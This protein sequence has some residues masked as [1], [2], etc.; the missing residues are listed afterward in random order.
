MKKLAQRVLLLA[1]LTSSLPLQAFHSGVAKT[2]LTSLVLVGTQLRSAN[3][4]LHFAKSVSEI[5]RT[6]YDLLVETDVNF[7][8]SFI[9]TGSYGEERIFLS[10]FDEK[11]HIE[12]TALYNGRQARAIERTKDGGYIIVGQRATDDYAQV[13]KLDDDF[14]PVW[15]SRGKA[16]TGDF[17]YQ[18][19]AVKEYSDGSA[20]VVVGVKEA[21][22]SGKQTLFLW[23]ISKKG[24]GKRLVEFGG[25]NPAGGYDLLITDDD[26]VVVTGTFGPGIVPSTGSILLAEFD[27]ATTECFVSAP[28]CL[29]WSSTGMYLENLLVRGLLTAYGMAEISEGGYV[30][31]GKVTSLDLARTDLF[32][33][34]WSATG[35]L[36]FTKILQD[37]SI[38]PSLYSSEGRAVVEDKNGNFIITGLYEDKSTLIK[39]LLLLKVSKAGNFKWA[40]TYHEGN[41]NI[42]YSI[43]LGNR[44]KIVVAGE[45]A[46]NEGDIPYLLFMQWGNQGQGCG[47]F[48]TTLYM[49]KVG[50]QVGIGESSYVDEE[51]VLTV[52]PVSTLGKKSLD[53]SPL[54]MTCTVSTLA[55]I[56]D[57]ASHVHVAAFPLA[58][59]SS[60]LVGGWV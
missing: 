48:H 56:A 15:T 25:I 47:T 12:S 42:G 3:S 52:V 31:T 7:T 16:L 46:N 19:H 32:V 5:D 14:K 21:V 13:L 54:N 4:Q 44:D 36:K 18:P 49:Q 11:G 23:E 28:S 30:L 40:K 20:I 37:S 34:V 43:G 45:M 39:K 10:T 8:D 57:G 9:V 35:N 1:A 55:D 29:I 6:G 51:N 33:S 27:L 41:Y 2:L 53:E 26:K 22:S 24:K 58:L 59:I 60:L 38:D 50:M 17:S